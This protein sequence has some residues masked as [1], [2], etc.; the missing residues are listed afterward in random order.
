LTHVPIFPDKAS[1]Q[2]A[3][4]LRTHQ[5][6]DRS[7][8]RE[9]TA[10]ELPA[11][12]TPKTP[13]HPF[14]RSHSIVIAAAPEA[15]FDYVTNPK[16][17]PQ[18]LPSSHDI[19]CE[20]RPMRFGDTFH[21]HWSTRSGPVALDW[22]VIA[23]ERPRLW[24]GLTHMSVTGPIVVQYVCAEVEGGTKFTRTVRN[25]ARPKAPTSE[26]IARIDEEAELGLANI[27]RIV[28]SRA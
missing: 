2:Y 17:W 27:K 3:A 8:L 10:E 14:E 7:Q 19:D 11:M 15:V 18:W 28:E 9:Q 1:T 24:I 21:E 26:M 23:C 16:T 25:P 6:Q 20:D 4:P 22:L 12:T 5:E 13:T